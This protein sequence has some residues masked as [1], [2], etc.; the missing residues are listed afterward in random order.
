MSATAAVVRLPITLDAAAGGPPPF[1]YFPTPTLAGPA[2]LLLPIFSPNQ[3]KLSLAFS[4]V[5][6][7]LEPDNDS[8]CFW[9][10]FATRFLYSSNG[11]WYLQRGMRNPCKALRKLAREID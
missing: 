11:S 3:F 7:D 1:R 4:P 2:L 6:P 5:A 10:L 8:A 9:I